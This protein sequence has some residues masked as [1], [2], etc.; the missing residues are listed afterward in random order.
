MAI[1]LLS[2]RRFISVATKRCNVLEQ[3]INLQRF[4]LEEA[5]GEHTVACLER[6]IDEAGDV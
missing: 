5:K 4:T 3:G 2:L 1:P 6:A